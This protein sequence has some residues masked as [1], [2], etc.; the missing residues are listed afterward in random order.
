MKQNQGSGGSPLLQFS[1]LVVYWTAYTTLRPECSF[2]LSNEL[3]ISNNRILKK[4]YYTKTRHMTRHAYS[5]HSHILLA[6]SQLIP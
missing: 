2:I 6:H 5:T 4:K 1:R 3:C